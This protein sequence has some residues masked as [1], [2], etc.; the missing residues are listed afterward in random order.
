MPH[1]T[2]PG[3]ATEMVKKFQHVALLMAEKMLLIT[4]CMIYKK[5]FW[6]RKLM[7]MNVFL[8]L[9][10]NFMILDNNLGTVS[11]SATVSVLVKLGIY[12]V[13]VRFQIVSS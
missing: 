9:S 3:N 5:L 1:C 8:S 2:P 11:V 4:F 7:K 12:I 10:K 6:P 13:S